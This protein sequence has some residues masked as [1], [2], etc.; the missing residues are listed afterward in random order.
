MSGPIYPCRICGATGPDD[1][2]WCFIC[3][4]LFMTPDPS[5]A[6]QAAPEALAEGSKDEL[7]RAL[8]AMRTQAAEYG[9]PTSLPCFALADAALSRVEGR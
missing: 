5:P 2:R 7:V 1:E 3:D 6:A 4:S 8:R 9:M